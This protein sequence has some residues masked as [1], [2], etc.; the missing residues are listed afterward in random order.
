MK[1]LRWDAPKTMEWVTAEKPQP[2]DTE[3]LIRVQT[4]GI[5][6]SEIEGYLGHN[7]L[8]I[9][10]LVMGHECFGHVESVGTLAAQ[11]GIRPGQPVV[12]NPLLRCGECWHC[13]RGLPQLC[14]ERRLIGVHRP[15]AFAQWVVV[16]ASAVVPVPDALPAHR[17]VLAEPLA[18][19]LRAVR[20]ALD[21]H[22]LP[23]VLVL[24]AGG[25]GLLAAACAKRL[26]AASVTIADV[27]EE[28]LRI[29]RETY[30][31]AVMNPQKQDL[32]AYA[33]SQYGTDGVEVI[34][35][36]AGFQSTR[37]S[38][39]RAVSP[40]GTVMNIGLGIDQTEL[41]INATIRSEIRMLGSF[42][43]A[44]QDFDDAV[45]L[46]VDG[47]VTEEGWTEVRP[48]AQ[49]AAAFDDLVSGRVH[50]GKIILEPW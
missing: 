20:R 6:G 11:R 36:A 34:I 5:C 1:T 45:R 33:R 48:L 21:G 16:P 43:Y 40:G 17:A 29:A 4:V 18:C 14:G 31:D 3:V 2:N 8:R 28:R 13:R 10:P 39:I 19:S 35:D 12:I 15:G 37:E 42:C 50:A 27:N 41:P 7:S 32:A 22:V 44:D 38:A 26:G 46:L 49:G 9:P 47:V 25:I 24:G 23:H 30:A